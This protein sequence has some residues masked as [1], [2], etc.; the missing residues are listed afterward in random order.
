MAVKNYYHLF[1]VPSSQM[2]QILYDDDKL[3]VTFM[4]LAKF[5]S[6][7]TFANKFDPI[8]NPASGAPGSKLIIGKEVTTNF[9]DLPGIFYVGFLKSTS[10]KQQSISS[11]NN[12]VLDYARRGEVIAAST[13]SLTYN[14]E[15][16]ATF[17]DETPLA[18]T[19]NGDELA[20]LE[21]GDTAVIKC[22]GTLCNADITV[23][24][25]TIKCAGSVMADDVTVVV[26]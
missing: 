20:E 21:R 14:G 6:I 5:S 17:E 10:S 19:Y 8:L 3:S 15:A 18:I 4:S 25:A 26:C 16:I 2:G 11:G 7:A 1:V 9:P 13:V 22:D 12:C 24:R 23:G